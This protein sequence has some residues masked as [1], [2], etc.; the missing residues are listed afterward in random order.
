MFLQ[1]NF[2]AKELSENYEAGEQGLPLPLPHRATGTISVQV[3]QRSL[4]RIR[5][6]L[7][8]ATAG[9]AG[10]PIRAAH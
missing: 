9:S 10:A 7:R 3:E 2:T 6:A 1:T 8:A 4:R 5:Q